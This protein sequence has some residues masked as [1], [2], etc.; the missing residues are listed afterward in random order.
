MVRNSIVYVP[1]ISE[2]RGIHRSI[3]WLQYRMVGPC[4]LLHRPVSQLACRTDDSTSLF[5]GLVRQFESCM[6]GS[7]GLFL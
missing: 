3:G 2:N 5:D 1:Y 4:G 6:D 7:T